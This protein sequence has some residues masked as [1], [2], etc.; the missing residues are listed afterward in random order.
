VF[1]D[2]GRFACQSERTLVNLPRRVQSLIWAYS[3]VLF[4]GWDKGNSLSATASIVKLLPRQ[5]R[6]HNGHDFDPVVQEGSEE[7][8]VN[9]LTLLAE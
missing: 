2:A 6:C 1:P 8:T 9:Q 4:G 3:S 5:H 7:I